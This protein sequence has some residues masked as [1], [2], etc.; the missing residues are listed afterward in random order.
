MLAPLMGGEMDFDDDEEWET[1]EGA[2]EEG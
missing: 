2:P 1:E